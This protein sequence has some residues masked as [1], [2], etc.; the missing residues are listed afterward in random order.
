[1][2]GKSKPPQLIYQI[3]VTLNHVQPAIWR[4]FQVDAA[5]TLSHLHNVL[6]T[7]M[8]W[9][10]GHLHQFFIGRTCYSEPEAEL[11]GAISERETRLCDVAKVK[12]KFLYEYDF[13][14]GW[15]HTLVVEKSLPGNPQV[16]YPVCLAGKRAC[17]PED[18]GGPYGYADFLEAIANPSHPEHEGLRDWIGG[19]LDPEAFNLNAVNTRLLGARRM[20]L[21]GPDTGEA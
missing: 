11:E 20:R 4:R 2:P 14:D 10:G 15:E 16:R 12:T 8:G 21:G 3:K 17:P 6:Q 18:C 7:V 13:G 5:R 19:H 9:D 1:M